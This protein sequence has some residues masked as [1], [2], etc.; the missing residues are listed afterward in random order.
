MHVVFLFLAEKITARLQLL[1]TVDHDLSAETL[2]GI[3]E[4]LASEDHAWPRS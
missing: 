4:I 3:V 2:N 1:F